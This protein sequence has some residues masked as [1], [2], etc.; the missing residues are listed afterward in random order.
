[1]AGWTAGAVG[2]TLWDALE[3]WFGFVRHRPRRSGAFRAE[4]ARDECECAG[5]RQVTRERELD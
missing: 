2:E 3:G 5:V 4:A 1:M